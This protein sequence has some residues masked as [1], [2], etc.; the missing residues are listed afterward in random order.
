MHAI[1]KI[2]EKL[3]CNRL[4]SYVEKNNIL[5]STQFGF[6]KGISTEDA[7]LEFLE[8][9]YNSINKSE[10]LAAVCLDLSK[11]FDT[12]NHNILL[13]K[14]HHLGFRGIV[15]DWFKS[16]LSNRVNYVSIGDCN[17][18]ARQIT[19]GV[20]QGSNL[21]P[22]LFLLYINDMKNSSPSLKFINFADDTTVYS[23]GSNMNE[24]YDVLA[25]ELLRVGEWL[26]ANRLSLNI[27][28]TSYMIVTNR[29]FDEKELAL[30]G[31][32]IQKTN[33]I[34]FLGVT[35]DDRLSFNEH[36]RDLVKRISMSTGLLYRV[37]TL[38][39]LKVKLNAYYALIYSRISYAI[40]VWGK[41]S[42]GNR[43]LCVNALKRVLK[44][45]FYNIDDYIRANNKLLDYD[46]IFDY[47]TCLKLYKI[48]HNN[49]H[50]YF[51]DKLTLLITNHSY[52]TRF[53]TLANFNTPFF[54]KSRCQNSF[55]Y[56]STKIWNSIPNYIR[57][58][59]SVNIFKKIFNLTPV[60][61]S[62]N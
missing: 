37:S 42:I 3:M 12:V 58:A 17:S 39:P 25:A 7:I 53:N 55:I 36:V 4:N 34:K 13:G 23:I 44:V 15:H 60:I 28:K 48:L 50:E 40:T 19:V 10:Y 11:A 45:I 56:Q 57:Y 1:S 20:P 22:L 5:S 47:F 26:Y 32:I 38:V 59:Q 6:R 14:L 8:D 41:S 51:N 61:R 24:M 62:L 52:G 16:Y 31:K 30:S 46:S 35:I 21:G 43:N 18:V 27:D 2:S 9:A 29:K 33:S 49:N 54:T